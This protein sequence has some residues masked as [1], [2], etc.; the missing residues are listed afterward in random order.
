MRPS[1]ENTSGGCT[2]SERVVICAHAGAIRAGEIDLRRAGTGRDE[3]DVTAVRRP[4]WR[5]LTLLAANEQRRRRRA[6]GRYDPD[7]S[8]A[9]AG[10]RIGRRSDER[11]QSSIR[12]QLRIGNPNRANRSWMV[13]GRAA[14][15]GDPTARHKASAA[16]ARAARLMEPP[17]GGSMISGIGD[18]VIRG[19]RDLGI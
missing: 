15:A 1:G 2:P 13:I 18:F 6:V 19:F 7:V 4:A 12:R 17:L 8:G 14:T 11:H 9:R 5:V 3:C 16:K 10:V